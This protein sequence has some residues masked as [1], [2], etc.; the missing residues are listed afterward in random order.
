MSDYETRRV[1]AFAIPSI[2]AKIANIRVSILRKKYR[3]EKGRSEWA[4]MDSKGKKVLR[5]FGERKP[6]DERV[7]KEEKRIQYFKH[8]GSKSDSTLWDRFPVYLAT[9]A[10]NN[11]IKLLRHGTI[12]DKNIFSVAFKQNVKFGSYSIRN[13]PYVGT[14]DFDETQLYSVIQNLVG[15]LAAGDKVA[16]DV[17]S[18]ILH[19]LGILWI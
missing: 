1:A 4:L 10:A 17:A 15:K 6:S 2:A 12:P 11:Y 13:D 8:Q 19:T 18:S 9:T 14:N 3:K 7:Q 16:G 5:W